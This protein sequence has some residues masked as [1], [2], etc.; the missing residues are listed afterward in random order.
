MAAIAQHCGQAFAGCVLTDVPAAT[1]NPFAGQTLIMHVRECR[2]NELYIPFHVGDDRSRTW[3]VTRTEDGVRLK[4]DHRHDDGSDDV[5]TLYGG[6]TASSGTALR[7]EFPVDSFSIEM[8]ER[9]DRAVSVT[10]VWAMEIE[11]GQR[12]LYELSRP[13]GRLF[14]VEFDLSAPVPAPPAPW[15][16]E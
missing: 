1:E 16:H 15:G 4:H 5:V 10:N 6:D 13:G 3:I 8:F 2:D 11:A 7:Q 12:F 9:E 14:Q